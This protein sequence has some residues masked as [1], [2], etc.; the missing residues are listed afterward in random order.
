MSFAEAIRA[1]KEG[2][3]IDLEV[4]PGSRSTVVP[5]GYNP[6]RKRIEVR[7]MAPPEKGKANDELIRALSGLFS[8]PSTSIE[9]TSGATNSRKSVLIR[10]VGVEAVIKLMG[11]RLDG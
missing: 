6:W 8:I 9:I 1:T 2:A 7:L 3:V 10:G 5:S 11:A 4:S